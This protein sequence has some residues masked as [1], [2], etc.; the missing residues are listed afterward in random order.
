MAGAKRVFER[1][2]GH[3]PSRDEWKGAI[4]IVDSRRSAVRLPRFRLRIWMLMALVAISTMPLGIAGRSVRFSRRA[5]FHARHELDGAAAVSWRSRGGP[6]A[7]S[8]RAM[9]GLDTTC[10]RP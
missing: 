5:A 2:P 1:A 3:R 8:F 9:S 10:Y 6:G 4:G 7:N